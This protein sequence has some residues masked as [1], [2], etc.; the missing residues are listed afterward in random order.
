[1]AGIA[2]SSSVLSS[3]LSLQKSSTLLEV[4]QG[5]LATGRKVDS[6]LDDASA[7]FTAKG[8]EDRASDFSAIKDSIQQ[9][10]STLKTAS[11]GI[12]G[13]E[14]LVQ[15]LKGIINSAQ[16][17]SDATE[18]TRLTTQY[19]GLLS[20]IDQLA[21]DATYNGTNMIKGT[22]NDLTVNFNENNSSNVTISGIASNSTGLGLSTA[23]LT[24]DNGIA[25][26]SSQVESAL[27]TLRTTAATLGSNIA[28]L[29]TRLDFTRN[30]ISTLQKGAG[31]LTLA[32]KNEEIANLLA[33]QTQQQLATNAL[34]LTTRTEQ[35]VLSLLG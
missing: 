32:D 11:D 4:T 9:G 10:V 12:A 31:D 22:P 23:T 8:L 27:G 2:L 25:A 35:A 29:T 21:N 26:A 16:Q 34:G 19:N 30:H 3:L 14:K 15:Q 20:Q 18:R 28:L 6:A 17:T 7:F 33:L 1:M 24:T 5:R 13:I